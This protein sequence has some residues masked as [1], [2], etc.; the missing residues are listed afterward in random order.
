MASAPA[1]LAVVDSP[2]TANRERRRN[3]RRDNRSLAISAASAPPPCNIS[4]CYGVIGGV[5]ISVSIMIH[6]FTRFLAA[7]SNTR[8]IAHWAAGAHRQN[9]VILS[10]YCSRNRLDRI[11]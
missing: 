5:I 3:R 2:Q 4:Y 10:P 11:T 7:C 9:R 1:T 8:Y 6:F